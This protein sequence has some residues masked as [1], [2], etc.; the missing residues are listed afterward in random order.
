MKLFNLAATGSFSFFEFKKSTER[1]P[2]NT[3]EATGIVRVGISSNV[4]FCR[5]NK[6]A[7]HVLR[8]KTVF[9]EYFRSGYIRSEAFISQ[10]SN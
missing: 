10:F 2:R 6:Y 4:Y 3:T 8:K 5:V 7:Q 1:L 9:S